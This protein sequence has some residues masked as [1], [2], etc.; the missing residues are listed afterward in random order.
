[1]LFCFTILYVS[2]FSFFGVVG[3]STYIK[4]PHSHPCCISPNVQHSYCD[5]RKD[6]AWCKKTCDEDPNCKG[7]GCSVGAGKINN[8]NCHLAITGYAKTKCK[9]LNRACS[10]YFFDNDAPIDPNA[11]CGYPTLDGCHVKQ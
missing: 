8:V 7:Y 6:C 1:M 2:T 10:G 9:G 5:C 11:S 3:G 4:S